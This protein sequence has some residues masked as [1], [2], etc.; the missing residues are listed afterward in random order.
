MLSR[1]CFAVL[2]CVALSPV[3]AVAADE[4]CPDVAS[5][6]E[7]GPK[8]VAGVQADI[9]RLNLCV[10]RARL[11]KDLDEV[12]KQRDDMLKKVTDPAAALSS[13]IAGVGGIPPLP[14]AALPPVPTDVTGLKPGDVRVTGAK[15]SP[16]G[17]GGK[18]GAAG[19]SP[20]V[21]NQG[22]KVRKIWGQGI[23]MRAQLTNGSGTLLNVM[24]GD[25][26]PDGKAV[27]LVSIKGVTTSQ[28]GKITD[29]SW[30]DSSD[31]DTEKSGNNAISPTP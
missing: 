15:G 9:E 16:L 10:Q 21:Q 13:E 17:G 12:A 30:D 23:T 28:N 1:F 14:S 3:A 31:S 19:T 18:G 6:K 29:L 22:W 20:V 4:L 25:T 24:K 5:A 11:L 8:D 2:L 26:L 7:N 27:E